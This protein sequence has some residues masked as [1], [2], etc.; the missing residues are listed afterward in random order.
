MHQGRYSQRL[1]SAI[2]LPLKA[3]DAQTADNRI[4]N[5]SSRMRSPR[6]ESEWIYPLRLANTAPS[7]LE[8]L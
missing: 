5:V 8:T 4:P 7:I 6:V 3:S 2:S 1:R